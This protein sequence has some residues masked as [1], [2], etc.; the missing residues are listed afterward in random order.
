MTVT[1]IIAV[2]ADN[3]AIIVDGVIVSAY[4]CPAF[5][6]F[7][8][9]ITGADIMHRASTSITSDNRAT[10]GIIN[11]RLISLNGIATASSLNWAG[12][13]SG[14]GIAALSACNRFIIINS[15]ILGGNHTSSAM[16][17]GPPVSPLNNPLIV[18]TADMGYDQSIPSPPAS[19]RRTIYIVRGN[20]T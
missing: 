7:S 2:T 14:N 6:A 15:G 8:G 12:F 17:T 10:E 11:A 4:S 1:T 18:K 9:G 16:A 5:S 19:V 20:T 13:I 3:T